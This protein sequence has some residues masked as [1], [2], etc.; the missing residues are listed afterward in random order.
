MARLFI[1]PRE[2]DLISDL[3][4][5]IIKDVVGQKIYYYAIRVDITQIHDIYEEAID[6][7]FDPPIEIGC[8]VAWTPDT[9]VTNRFGSENLYSIE[10][11]LHYKDL[12]DKDISVKQGDY[13]SYGET[14]FE[15][16]STT[17]QSNIYG[18]IEYMTGVKLLGKQARKGL[19][20]KKLHGPTD[21]GYYPGDP[22]AI[23]RSFVQQ[24]G[25]AENEDGPTGDKRALI[26]QGKLE[27][28]PQPAPAKVSPEGDPEEISSAFY[29]ES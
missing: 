22:D 24:R 20:D 9:V 18:E 25:F 3:T 26:E 6:K 19:I 29:D 28:P 14:F 1:T 21:E 11:Y 27:L 16:T 8:T 23:Q 13:F 5:E 10:A 7:Y 15:I 17:W 4:K 2:Q 12:I